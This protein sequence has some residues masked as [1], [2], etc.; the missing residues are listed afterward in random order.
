MIEPMEEAPQPRLALGPF[1]ITLRRRGPDEVRRVGVPGSIVV[2]L[3]IISLWLLLA[4][5]TRVPEEKEAVLAAEPPVP[6][7]FVSPFP[8]P[9]PPQPQPVPEIH[10]APPPAAT[11]PLR[12]QEP[13][14]ETSV[15]PPSAKARDKAQAAGK[16]DTKP[17]GGESGGPLPDPTAGVPEQNTGTSGMPEERKDLD[18]RLRDFKRALEAPVPPSQKGGGRGTGGLSMPN[19]PTVGTGIGNL[20][21]ESND[22]DWSSYAR[23]IHGLIWRAWH[24]RLLATSGVFE[25]WSEEHQRWLIDA[26]ARI[27][28]TIQRSGQV[29]G[30]AVETPSGVFPF[31][32]S[33]T[34]ALREVL[35]PPLPADF[36]RDSERIRGTFIGEDINIRTMRLG[37][38]DLKNRG[39][40]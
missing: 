22:Y 8:P 24:N 39:V 19:V 5:Y 14:K 6:I 33:A 15:T 23:S 32:D 21:F 29:T 2:H 12:M 9:P 3:A 26:R 31:D 13:P 35:L 25:R 4:P 18:G 27:V 7:T 38:Q 20:E 11:K 16:N 30:V 1:E 36:P 10:R 40:F 34:D 28:F 37:L 17:A